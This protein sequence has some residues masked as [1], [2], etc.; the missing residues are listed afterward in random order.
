[1]D[2]PQLNNKTDC[3]EH[4]NSLKEIP[5]CIFHVWIWKYGTTE[6]A[7]A[8]SVLWGLPCTSQYKCLATLLTF[9]VEFNKTSDAK[10]LHMAQA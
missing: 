7:K 6:G 5:L 4:F 8:L 3:G 2:S 1:M 9:A 10:D